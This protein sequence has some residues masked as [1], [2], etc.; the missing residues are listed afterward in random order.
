MARSA[1]LRLREGNCAEQRLAV[2]NRAM[3]ERTWRAAYHAGLRSFL[4]T[5]RDEISPRATIF[6][7]MNLLVSDNHAA[8]SRTYESRA[9]R[10]LCKAPTLSQ[11][12]ARIAVRFL[13][14]Q[15]TALR[16]SSRANGSGR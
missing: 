12:G 4:L 2:V 3:V 5:D 13:I 6:L 14:T 15:R 11:K 1:R 7:A 10:D 16:M 9:R 8:C